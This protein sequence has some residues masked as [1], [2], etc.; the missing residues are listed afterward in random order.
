MCCSVLHCA[1][2]Y[3]SVLQCVAVCCSALQ[4]VAV[5]GSVLQCVAVC[6]SVLQCAAE[7]NL[8]C[9]FSQA[10]AKWICTYVK[11][12]M[13]ACK[14]TQ[15][16]AY[17]PYK[18]AYMHMYIRI[19]MDVYMY[20]YIYIYEYIFNI[21]THLT[22]CNKTLEHAAT[23]CNTLQHT[24]THCNALQHTATHCN[25]PAEALRAARPD[26]CLRARL[27]KYTATL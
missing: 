20:I 22:N 7:K 10:P 26:A 16:H 11:T 9:K 27:G 17:L 23:H 19:N 6:C 25:T 18:H 13:H 2:V 14:Q 3:G 15:V 4:C 1:A 21:S 8:Q 24:A 12:D 5:Y